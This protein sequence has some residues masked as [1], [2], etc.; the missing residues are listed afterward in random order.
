VANVDGKSRASE[1]TPQRPSSGF[2]DDVAS[3]AILDGDMRMS[4]LRLSIS[5][6]RFFAGMLLGWNKSAVVATSPL[7]TCKSS[8]A[9]GLVKTERKLLAAGWQHTLVS[10]LEI[11]MNTIRILSV[12]IVLALL[13]VSMAEQPAEIVTIPLDQIWAYKMPGTR[14]IGKLE[15]KAPNY[16]YGPLFGKIRESLSKVLAQGKIAESGFAVL[17]MGTDAL[18]KAHDILVRNMKPQQTVAI[19]SEVSL[20]FFSYESIAYVHLHTVERQ[21]RVINIRYRFVPHE[22]ME[23]TEHLALIPLG[24]LPSG[25]YRVNVIQAPM[26]RKYVGSRFP[27]VSDEVARRI[28]CRSFSFSVAE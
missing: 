27:P 12:L 22:T 13:G 8:R 16:A 3:R 19:G 28:V 11:P 15:A 17:G 5:V 10:G 4:L 9:R 21:G 25:K 20:V 14:D 1:F 23:V 18:R 24:K 6:I 7:N 26:D 2:A